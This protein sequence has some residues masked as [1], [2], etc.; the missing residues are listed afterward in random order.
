MEVEHDLEGEVF[1]LEVIGRG[2][3]QSVIGGFSRG[4]L[5]REF[6]SRRAGSALRCSTVKYSAVQ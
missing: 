6:L 5:R 3:G 1:S 4:T 2:L